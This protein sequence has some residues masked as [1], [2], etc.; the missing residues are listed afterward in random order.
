MP[1]EIE[2]QMGS[3]GGVIRDRPTDV[4]II[5]Q[6]RALGITDPLAGQQQ[7]AEEGTMSSAQIGA[8]DGGH[9]AFV[10]ALEVPIEVAL[11]DFRPLVLSYYAVIVEPIAEFSD[12][13]RARIG[14]LAP[15]FSDTFACIL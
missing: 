15:T 3:V 9:T 7:P 1:L 10:K 14:L 5:S 12:C 6:L 4:G 8:T 2:F 13:V 11:V